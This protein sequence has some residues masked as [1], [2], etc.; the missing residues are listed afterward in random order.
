MKKRGLWWRV[1]L[2]GSMVSC[3]CRRGLALLLLTLVACE[4]VT[5]AHAQITHSAVNH[6]RPPVRRASRRP[7]TPSRR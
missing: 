5:E 6:P 2:S 7:S 4:L 1:S 3:P